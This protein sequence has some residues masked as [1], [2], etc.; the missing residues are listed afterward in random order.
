M[1]VISPFLPAQELLKGSVCTSIRTV[2][3]SFTEVCDAVYAL[4]IGLR[5][6]G[7]TGGHPKFQLLT[8]LQDSLKMKQYISSN[9][10]KVRITMLIMPSHSYTCHAF[11]SIS[12]SINRSIKRSNRF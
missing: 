6:L 2:L 5:F 9:V 10:A 11:L 3:R 1:N 7:K 8:Y 4:E 12:Q